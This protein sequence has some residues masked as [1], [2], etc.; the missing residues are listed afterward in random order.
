MVAGEPDDESLANFAE[1]YQAR[2]AVQQL[3]ARMVNV[4]NCWRISAFEAP[5]EHPLLG[6]TP[7][8]PDKQCLQ[9]DC[10]VS[11]HLCPN[12]APTRTA[13]HMHADLDAH[14]KQELWLAE[15][16]Q[17]LLQQQVPAQLCAEAASIRSAAEEV[18]QQ[19]GS[20]D[21]CLAELLLEVTTWL[22]QPGRTAEVPPEQLHAELVSRLKPLLV[23]GHLYSY[24]H[25]MPSLRNLPDRVGLETLYGRACSCADEL[26][27][28]AHRDPEHKQEL[29]AVMDELR[30]ELDLHVEG[31]QPVLDSLVSLH[32]HCEQ[33][34]G[35]VDAAAATKLQAML[36]YRKLC[37]R[38]PNQ[39]MLA[40]LA[41]L[42]VHQWALRIRALG[43]WRS[44]AACDIHSY[45][46]FCLESR[47]VVVA[48]TWL[49]V[50]VWCGCNPAGEA[51]N[52]LGGRRPRQQVDCK[53]LYQLLD[54]PSDGLGMCCLFDSLEPAASS[55]PGQP[56][57]EQDAQQQQQ[58]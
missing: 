39:L 5:G 14:C 42:E 44:L 30:R 23:I 11:C 56:G 45:L 21:S 41:A 54:R 35:G 32:G 26:R 29:D 19:H 50:T 46:C 4:N 13:S 1:K 38:I 34:L 57:L 18:L 36:S 43:K 9:H 3:L 52:S 58:Q 33:Q 20:K 47:G 10:N 53:P 24:A 16:A 17:Q 12:P 6:H 55:S 8:A 51:N 7:S 40:L 49:R 28:R 31:I 22:L 27:A 2:A 25:S 37:T 48:A 15:R